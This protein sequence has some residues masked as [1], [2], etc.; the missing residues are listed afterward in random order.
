M[1]KTITTTLT[2]TYTI[3]TNDDD[4]GAPVINRVVQDGSDVTELLTSDVNG[5]QRWIIAED[6]STN[7]LNDLICNWDIGIS[8]NEY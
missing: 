3:P 7:A 2:I 1:M 8:L 6:E 4:D 5:Q